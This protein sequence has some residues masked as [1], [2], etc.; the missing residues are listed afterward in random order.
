MVPTASLFH[1]RPGWKVA[2][3]LHPAP[4][5]AGASTVVVRPT[6]SADEDENE[7][8]GVEE[9][10]EEVWVGGNVGAPR[11]VTAGKMMEVVV[12][13]RDVYGNHRGVGAWCWCWYCTGA[14]RRGRTRL[15]L[16]N[17]GA[18]VG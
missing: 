3:D 12:Q 17:K 5:A 7:A 4:T 18:H 15:F 16:D 13:A 6:P 11:E 9:E 1:H 8:E 14:W 10:E 2:V